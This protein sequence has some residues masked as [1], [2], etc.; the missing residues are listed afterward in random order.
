MPVVVTNIARAD[1]AATTKLAMYGVATVHEAQG[2]TGLMSAR[3]RPIYRGPAISGTAV[4]VSI[5]PGDNWMITWPLNNA[6]RGI[7]WW[8]VRFR[9]PTPDISAI[10]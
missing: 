8:L 1:Q 10:C 5:P 7:F 3:L 4:T 6:A 2:R 9:A